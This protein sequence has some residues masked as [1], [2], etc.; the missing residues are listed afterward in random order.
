MSNNQQDAAPASAENTIFTHKLAA[1]LMV[2][3]EMVDS[4]SLREPTAKEV[5]QFGYPFRVR[6]DES[7][8]MLGDIA[9]KYIV[10]LAAAPPDAID[11]M[12]A[13]DFMALQAGLMDFFAPA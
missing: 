12:A 13:K 9:H 10:T 2:H 1:K 5:R 6:G 8:E 7:V 11:K 3:G 4:I